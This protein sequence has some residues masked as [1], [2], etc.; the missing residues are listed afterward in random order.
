MVKSL[1]RSIARV[2]RTVVVGFQRQRSKPAVVVLLGVV[3]VLALAGGGYIGFELE[4]QLRV[5]SRHLPSIV[6]SSMT[7]PTALVVCVMNETRCS[8]DRGGAIGDS[9]N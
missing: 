3:L 9:E 7:S 6:V 1:P 2:L 4:R 5:A 8:T